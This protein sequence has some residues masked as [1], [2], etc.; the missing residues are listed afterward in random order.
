MSRY[1]ASL[2]AVGITAVSHLYRVPGL[3]RPL[4]CD[5]VLP[6][7]NLLIEAKASGGRDSIRMAIGQL[8]DYRRLEETKPQLAVLCHISQTK[9][10][11]TCF[12][13]PVSHL[14]GLMMILFLIQLMVN[15]SN[16]YTGATYRRQAIVA[17]RNPLPES[18]LRR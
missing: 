3:A 1:V 15:T 7:K 5:I 2:A 10:F 9:T 11:A 13:R 14:S 18:P 16:R 17:R 8:L 4:F 12:P 6:E